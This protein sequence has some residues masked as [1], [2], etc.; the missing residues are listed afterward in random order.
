MLD[1]PRGAR[2]VGYAMRGLKFKRND[3]NFQDVPWHRVVNSQ[4]RISLGGSSKFRQADLLLD[5]GVAVDQDFAVDLD[6][7]LWQ[8]LLPHEIKD[9]LEEPYDQ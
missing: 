1:A 3:P 2:A 7:Y 5:E 8:G 9:L 4:G 6:K